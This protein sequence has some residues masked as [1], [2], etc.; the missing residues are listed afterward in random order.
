MKTL[1]SKLF[2]FPLYVHLL[3]VIAAFVF[4]I[5]LVLKYLEVYTNHN[6]AVVVPD[7]RRLQIEEAAP[8]FERNMLRFTVID[9]IYSTEYEPGAVVELSPEAESKVKKNRMISL[10]INAKTEK[11]VPIPDVVDISYRQ[12]YARLKS[13]GFD[14]EPKYV[15]GDF[16]DLT[17]GLEYNGNPVVSGT[18]LPISAKLTLLVSNGNREGL[19]D[20]DTFDEDIDIS[21]SDESWF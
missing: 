14:V 16:R 5:Y 18:R 2:Y 15:P 21:K 7:V 3:A 12:V 10:T 4:A 6:Q 8:L 1:F 19:E 20:G 17:I 9:S 11:T 13:L